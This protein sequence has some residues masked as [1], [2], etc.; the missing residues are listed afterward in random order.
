[1]TLPLTPEVLAAAYDYLATTEPFCRWNLPDSEDVVFRVVRDPTRC[2]FY[3]RDRYDRRSISI[4]SAS[5]GHSSTLL[6]I[7]AHELVHLHEDAAGMAK[8]S[9]HSAA[10]RKLAA[11]VCRVH[12][13][14][15]KMF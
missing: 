14:D 4:S 2:G 15:P 10:F 7:M 6:Q 5:V 8:Q 1:M 9:E 3:R 12:G 13:F 11:L